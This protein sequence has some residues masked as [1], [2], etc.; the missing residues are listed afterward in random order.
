MPT[1]KTS[2]QKTLAELIENQPCQ[3]CKNKKV[4][5]TG[6]HAVMSNSGSDSSKESGSAKTSEVSDTTQ[7]TAALRSDQPSLSKFLMHNFDKQS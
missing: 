5:C 7:K 6:A 4:L 3:Q 1:P 2:P